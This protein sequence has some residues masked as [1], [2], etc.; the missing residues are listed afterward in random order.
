MLCLGMTP[1]DTPVAELSF[2][3]LPHNEKAEETILGPLGKSELVG[4]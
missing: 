3:W 4:L 2:L 1:S